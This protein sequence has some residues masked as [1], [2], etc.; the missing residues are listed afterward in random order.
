MMW[1]SYQPYTFGV[2]LCSE[3]IGDQ[4]P[5]FEF[6]ATDQAHTFEVLCDHF[7]KLWLTSDVDMVKCPPE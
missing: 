7:E 3:L 2:G 4:L 5:I 1:R 6:R